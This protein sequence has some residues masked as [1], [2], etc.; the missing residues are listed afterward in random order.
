MKG[1]KQLKLDPTIYDALNKERVQVS[2]VCCWCL[3]LG[4]FV[5]VLIGVRA[6][7]GGASRA[8]GGG[9]CHWNTSKCRLRGDTSPAPL[10]P[11][12]PPPFCARVAPPHTKKD[13]KCTHTPL[14]S[15]S[16][17]LTHAHHNNHNNHITKPKHQ[18]NN[19]HENK[20]HKKGRRRHLHRGGERRGQARR[21]LRRVR[22]RVRFGGRGVRAAA[23]GRRAQAQGGRAGWWCVLGG[24]VVVLVLLS[25]G[26]V[27]IF[28]LCVSRQS[29]FA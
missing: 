17:T 20:K 23:Q 24:W 2:L 6:L 18:T 27:L 10:P 4:L 8:A 12:M 3:S 22:D 14:L 1:G 15:V 21:A 13:S 11:A 5:G 9:W 25:I 28:E 7:H 19:Q 16:L 26:G 29:A